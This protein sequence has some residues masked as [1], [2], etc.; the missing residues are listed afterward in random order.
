M[1]DESGDC[2]AVATAEVGMIGYE[3]KR[4]IVAR[5]TPEMRR[6]LSAQTLLLSSTHTHSAPGGYLTPFL[7][8]ISVKGIHRGVFDRIVN[9]CSQALVAA[10]DTRKARSVSATTGIIRDVQLN[11]SPT[12]YLANPAKERDQY[13][14]NTNEEAFTLLF[15]EIADQN[16]TNY[17][18]SFS[19]FGLHPTSMNFTNRLVSSDNRGYAA[20]KIEKSLG[21]AFVAAIPQ[22][23]EGD[24]SPNIDGAKCPDGSPCD[25]A[26]SSCKVGK[27]IAHGP[28]KNM[29]DSTKIIGERMAS[30]I[31][32][33]FKDAKRLSG[34]GVK[35]SAMFVDFSAA[36]FDME[37]ANLTTCSAAFGCSF[38]AG[39]I[40]GNPLE[41]GHFHQ[42]DT[43]CKNKPAKIF[44]TF[45]KK[46]SR[47]L[48]RCHFPKP[49]LLN[50]GEMERPW[51]WSPSV[52]ELQLLQIGDMLIVGLPFEITTMASRRLRRTMAEEANRLRV[53]FD[54]I[55]IA[56]LANDYADYLT[57]R[58]EYAEQRYEG[59]STVYGPNT[60]SAVQ[61][62]FRLLLQNLVNGKQI[63]DSF[64]TLRRP[65]SNIDRKYSLIPH[66][67]Y[68][69]G[70]EQGKVISDAHNEYE[71]GEIV[72]VQFYGANPRNSQHGPLMHVEK[73][74]LNGNSWEV[75]DDDSSW[76]TKIHW[77]R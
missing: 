6:C 52:L 42:G 66:V 3:M 75:F 4:A 63:P 14:S 34:S 20:W 73:L 47:H 65:A 12:A 25:A 48:K 54:H 11:R 62:H 19:W 23:A 70:H 21:S 38:A 49:I 1:Q 13:T 74:S 35:S 68:D 26:T 57:T 43:D 17:V 46:P 30:A 59:A 50:T 5:L 16:N 58:E 55:V 29:F 9:G 7:F 61:L 44:G 76:Y 71:Q 28:G 60:L 45:L 37:D 72:S 10:F 77:K 56:P 15:G 22:E 41:F 2:V 32:S 27:C 64:G 67:I 18:A 24:V 36:R 53:K 39:T 40:D 31:M 51:S 33:H 8:A 69:I